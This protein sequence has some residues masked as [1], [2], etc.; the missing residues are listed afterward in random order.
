MVSAWNAVRTYGGTIELKDNLTS[1]NVTFDKNVIVEAGNYNFEFD[2]TNT[3]A[4]GASLTVKG[5]NISVNNAIV[6][7]EGAK[8]VLNGTVNATSKLATTNGEVVIEAGSKVTAGNTVNAIEAGANAVVTLNAEE[9]TAGTIVKT[10]SI[11]YADVAPK[12]IVE[13]GK[14]TADSAAF[15]LG[16]GDLTINGGTINATGNG[17]HL[18]KGAVTINNGTINSKTYTIYTN[19]TGGD[20]ASLTINGG[21]ISSTGSATTA[22][23]LE[24]AEATYALNGGVVE[25]KGAKDLAAITLGAAFQDADGKLVNVGFIN[26]GS[27]L[28]KIVAEIENNKTGAMMDVSTQLVAEGVAITTADG[29]KVV[30]EGEKTTEPGATEGENNGE[31]TAPESQGN[32]ADA[33]NPNTSDNVY[34]LISMAVASVAGLFVTFKKTILS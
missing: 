4:D 25:S 11:A 9:M 21:N 26:G 7:N 12:I 23:D 20:E 8:L 33:K 19:A 27:Y 16:S 30:G 13:S 17:I 29:Y 6:V 32:T 2:G 31:V 3:I 18:V 10:N 15:Y 24:N 14:Y 1:Y 22:L 28:N 34:G 5:D